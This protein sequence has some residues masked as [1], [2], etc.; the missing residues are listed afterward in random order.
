MVDN[1]VYLLL[2]WVKELKIYRNGNSANFFVCWQWQRFW[3]SSLHLKWLLVF[4]MCFLRQSFQTL[5]WTI[6]CNASKY[7]RLSKIK[8]IK[9]N[10]AFYEVDHKHE[11]PVASLYYDALT[12]LLYIWTK[13]TYSQVISQQSTKNT[14]SWGLQT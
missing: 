8:K 9:D 7:I 14:A 13:S 12:S 5:G 3:K 1:F 6:S 2:G 4:G 10:G 11:N